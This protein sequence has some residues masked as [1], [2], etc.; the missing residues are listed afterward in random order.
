M[1][2]PIIAV[3]I[4]DVIAESTEAFRKV[5]NSHAGIDLQ[6]EDYRIEGPYGD[7]YEEV[8]RA[9]GVV[10]RI[11]KQALLDQMHYD[12]SHIPLMPGAEFAIGQLQKRYEIV[13]VTAR[14]EGW[15]KA[16]R[17]WLHQQF[18]A[19]PPRIYFSDAHLKVDDRKTKGEI[20]KEIGAKWMID[21][22]PEHCQS[23]L[24]HGVKAILFGEYGWHKNVPAGTVKC[25]DWQAVLEY[26]D[27][28]K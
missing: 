10:E 13:L 12:Q 25:K 16:T 7:Y 18:G 9:H 15:E 1:N 26:F 19:E 27:A 2:K 21:D 17:I 4:D 5:V 6:P 8:W 23:V 11:D 3:D 14:D 20:C 22:N 24:D 28:A